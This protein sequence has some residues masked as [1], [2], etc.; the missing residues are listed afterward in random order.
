MNPWR[1]RVRQKV[2]AGMSPGGTSDWG[3]VVR[4]KPHKK[5]AFEER[6]VSSGSVLVESWV[7]SASEFVNLG[8]GKEA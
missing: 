1:W 8:L 5:S 3:T 2:G 4:E 6:T 7:L